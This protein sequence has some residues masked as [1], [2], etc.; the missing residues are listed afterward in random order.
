MQ[1]SIQRPAGAVRDAQ[2]CRTVAECWQAVP[3]AAIVAL[4][5]DNV[6]KYAANTKILISKI[7]L[8]KMR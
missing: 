7:Q 1:V 6:V 2:A 3:A 8:R 4:H 5:A